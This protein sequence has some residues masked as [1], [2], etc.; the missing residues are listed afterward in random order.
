MQLVL[1][2][3]NDKFRSEIYIV[4][5]LL[6]NGLENLHIKKNDFTKKQLKSYINQIPDKFHSKLIIHSHY[7]LIFK[8]KL[9]GLHISRQFRNKKFKFKML[10]FT[11]K[12]FKRRINISCSCHNIDKLLEIP[13]HYSHVFISPIFNTENN[14]NPL[15]PLKT[16]EN[17]IPQLDF[18]VYATGSVN[19]NNIHQIQGIGLEGVGLKGS[20]WFNDDKQP[21]THFKESKNKLTPLS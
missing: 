3:S 15:F 1:F 13:K 8:F 9:K 4:I 21:L 20:I 6:E 5:K 12:Y 10:L 7:S 16:L 11:I 17:I 14:I 18:K 19:L 2:T